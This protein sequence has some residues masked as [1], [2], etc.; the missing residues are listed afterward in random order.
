M[1]ELQQANS[2]NFC[3]PSCRSW[4]YMLQLRSVQIIKTK[5]QEIN[6]LKKY[7]LCFESSWHYSYDSLA[8]SILHTPRI[9]LT[10]NLEIFLPNTYTF[11]RGSTQPGALLHICPIIAR[12][13]FC[14][15]THYIDCF[16]V[17]LVVHFKRMNRWFFALCISGICSS[18]VFLAPS[19]SGFLSFSSTLCSVLVC[20]YTFLFNFNVSRDLRQAPLN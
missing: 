9:L 20:L 1:W 6:Y 15:T 4:F 19:A 11:I 3:R 12:I 13:C 14:L 17:I 10:A 16:E 2:C 7:A 8:V 5:K 18:E